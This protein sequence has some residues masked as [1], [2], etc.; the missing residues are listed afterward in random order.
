MEKTTNSRTERVTD[1]K[2]R[3]KKLIYYAHP[4]K[5]MCDFCKSCAFDDRTN[6]ICMIAHEVESGNLPHCEARNRTDGR[7]IIWTR[8]KHKSSVKY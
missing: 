7:D 2:I 8:G 5:Y 4:V 3:Y 1:D 6:G